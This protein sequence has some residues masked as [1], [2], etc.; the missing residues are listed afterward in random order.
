M[1]KIAVF[2]QGFTKKVTRP[3]ILGF[4]QNH[5]TKACSFACH[6]KFLHVFFASRS[7]DMQCIIL[8][9]NISNR[10]SKDALEQLI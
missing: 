8:F 4:Y 1:N 3:N 10:K 2:V 6:P 9:L 5:I 7:R